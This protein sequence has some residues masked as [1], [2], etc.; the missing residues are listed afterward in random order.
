ML[1]KKIGDVL[2][3]RKESVSVE[4]RLGSSQAGQQPPHWPVEGRKCGN[5]ACREGTSSELRP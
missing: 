2:G 5:K 4:E 1:S 3:T